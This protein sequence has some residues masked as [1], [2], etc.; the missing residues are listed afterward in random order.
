MIGA[1]LVAVALT[2]AG[3]GGRGDDDGSATPSVTASAGPSAEAST[4]EPTGA[5]TT[6]EPTPTDPWAMGPPAVTLPMQYDNEE[7]AVAFVEYYIELTNYSYAE[8]DTSELEKWADV[9]C[10]GCNST[11]ENVSALQDGGYSVAGGRTA[12]DTVLSVE[13]IPNEAAYEVTVTQTSGEAQM[14]DQEGTAVR[15]DPPA[16]YDVDF[17]VTY[18]GPYDWTMVAFGDA[19]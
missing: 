6:P 9:D 10:V 15:T 1:G 19:E 17:V 16:T 8:L 14:L 7:G 4:P 13:S 2:V 3:C 11:I 5:E 18:N 12:I